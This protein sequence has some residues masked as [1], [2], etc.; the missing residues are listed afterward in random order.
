MRIGR[1]LKMN[2]AAIIKKIKA[3]ENELLEQRRLLIKEDGQRPAT[4]IVPDTFSEIFG[5]IEEKVAEHF[6]DFNYDPVSGEITVHGQRYILF[7]SDSMSYEFI[8]FIK[9]RYSDRSEKEAESIGHN[10]LYD[11]SKVIGK[12][13]SIA[14]NKSL[15]LKEPIEKLAAGPIHFAYTG[16]ANVEILP[17]S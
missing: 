10:Y 15:T 8:D 4:V 5:A 6:T 13:D 7:R 17:E 1:V 14:F 9:E 2:K 16:W 12:K 11:N 3:L